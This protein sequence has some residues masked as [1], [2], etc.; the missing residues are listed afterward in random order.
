MKRNSM[1]ICAVLLVLLFYILPGTVAATESGANLTLVTAKEVYV[2]GDTMTVEV[3]TDRELRNY[4][5]GI[6]VYYDSDVLQPNVKKCTAQAPLAVSN[7]VTVNGETALRISCFPGTTRNSLPAGVLAKLEFEA[8]APAE[9]TSIRM[10]RD[11]QQKPEQVLQYKSVTAAVP[12]DEAVFA[13]TPISV[14]GIRL[15]KTELTLEIEKS[16]TLNAAVLPEG[17]SNSTVIWQSSD[18][19][20]ATV[21][22]GRVTGMKKG[23]TVVSAT[24]VDGNFTAQCAVTVKLPPDAGY[25]VSMPGN[26]SSSVGGTV[27]IVPV[28]TNEKVTGYNA[29][30]M[31]FSYD[32]SK[33]QLMPLHTLDEGME[34][35]ITEISE[36][37]NWV[38]V[39]RYG[40]TVTLPD[41]GSKPIELKFKPLVTG[42]SSVILLEAR[43]DHSVNALIENTAKA[44]VLPSQKKTEIIVGGYPVE[45]DNAFIAVDGK[46]TVEPESQFVFRP[47]SDNYVYNLSECT[48]GGTKKP[49]GYER[50]ENGDVV[51][52]FGIP[53]VTQNVEGIFIAPD[54]DMC[55]II[56]KVTG[57]V[58]IDL[59][60]TDIRGRTYDV[61]FEDSAIGIFDGESK[62]TYGTDYELI[63]LRSGSS[64]II[65]VNGIAENWE[66]RQDTNEAGQTVYIILGRAITS[67]FS[68]GATGGSGGDDPNDPPGPSN[69]SDPSDPS[70]PS[71][72]SDDDETFSVEFKGTGKSEL[73]G[74]DTATRGTD[75]VFQ[76]DKKTGYTYKV[77]VTIGGETYYCDADGDTYIIDG[78]DI[79]GEIVITVT[80]TK[81]TSSTTTSSSSNKTQSSTSSKTQ[82][83][84]KKQVSVTFD[85]SGAEDAS[86]SNTAT[87]SQAYTFQI[88]RKPGFRY[89]VTAKVGTKE[90]TPTYDEQKGTYTI[91]AKDVTGNLVITIEKTSIVEVTEYITLDGRSI[92]LVA[93][94]GDVPK[95][96]IPQYDGSNMYWADDYEAYVWLVESARSDAQMYEDAVQ[97]IILS[98]GDKPTPVDHSGDVDLSSALDTYDARLVWEIYKGKFDLDTLEMQKLFAA[99][100][101]PDK[102]VNVQDVAAVLGRVL[103]QEGGQSA[104]E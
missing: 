36:T 24:T 47:V 85:G 84:A 76:L 39:L 80:R 69:P 33:L 48:M 20:V 46:L 1:N 12:A 75:Y 29:Y 83:S 68:I 103:M 42:K 31:T 63:Q 28:I 15:D 40:N 49:V 7:P 88:S 2:H 72:P 81:A 61:R 8:I 62:A 11:G 10:W 104:D 19:S 25:C 77:S 27:R 45:L 54:P 6:T 66:K 67:D 26:Q 102:K 58:V 100:V 60:D 89:S 16:A 43:V 79:N 5:M 71:E 94:S 4:G 86:G 17:A 96:Q 82:T 21:H 91:A 50:T 92:F 57:A 87:Q 53:T 55:F 98:K 30:D 41:A 3:I 70:D 51:I 93:Y 59:D 34:I 99:D 97:K 18:P 22:N 23:E 74:D 9:R 56:E 65:K 52:T 101:Y 90:V 14:T 78:E 35:N 95:G 32:P 64:P 38:Q 37:E 44:T 73:I 13:V